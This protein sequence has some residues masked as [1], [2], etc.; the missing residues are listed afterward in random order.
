MFSNSDS[1]TR[2]MRK[3][4]VTP[5][6]KMR[7]EYQCYICLKIFPLPS[8]F[9]RQVTVHEQTKD[10][11][12]NYCQKI[13][14]TPSKLKR[15]LEVHET[16]RKSSDKYPCDKCDKQYTQKRYLVKHIKTHEELIKPVV[17][18]ENK[19]TNYAGI[20]I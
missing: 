14:P 18:I 4:H 13:F 3:F 8:K 10:Y 15:H 19:L 1:L 5:V 12:C 9:K 17:L 11:T 16:S 6:E 2:H 7:K 20:F